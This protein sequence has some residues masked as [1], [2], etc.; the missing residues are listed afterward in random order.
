MLLLLLWGFFVVVFF[1]I[2]K[3]FVGRMADVREVGRIDIEGNGGKKNKKKTIEH[4][5]N[6]LGLKARPRPRPLT[7]G[8]NVDKLTK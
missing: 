4:E 7:P 3:R 1:K 5:G 6:R 8:K 2:R